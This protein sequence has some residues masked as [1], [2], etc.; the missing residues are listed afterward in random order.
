[1]LNFSQYT[2]I[3]MTLL[4]AIAIGAAG[5]SP[6]YILICL[7]FSIFPALAGIWV[8][9]NDEPPSLAQ[10]G[11]VFGWTALATLAVATTGGANSPA[12]ILFAIG[13]MT[14]FVFR[15]SQLARESTI[16]SVI[17]YLLAAALGSFGLLPDKTATHLPIGGVAAVLG[18]AQF[19]LLIWAAERDRTA[20]AATPAGATFARLPQQ[21]QRIPDNRANEALKQRNAYFASLGHD[22][23]SP[24]NAIMGYAETFKMNLKG[25][26]T[27]KQVDQASIIHESA[28]DL[29]ALVDDMM[30]L[31]KSEAGKLSI[32][33]EPLHLGDLGK[34]IMQQMQAMADRK[35]ISMTL[36][37][38]GE[39]WAMADAR[40][41]RRIW[42]NLISNAIKY[43]NEGGKVQLSASERPRH[44][45]ISVSDNGRGMT[46]EDLDRIASPFEM[47][48]NSSDKAGTGLGLANVR[49]FAEMHGGQVLIDTA[50]GEGARF[51]VILPKA[52]LSGLAPL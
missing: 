48:E 22:L 16:F 6:V 3:G 52:D 44:A 2:W 13:P 46:E 47:G 5:G 50:P 17:A 43:S 29:L 27:P 26:L 12:V 11:M 28:Q 4:A 1:M 25:N 39:P 37:T 18:I 49:R 42:Q 10:A 31:A 45:V 51:Q 14:A 40:L 30:D 7:A 20:R 15:N 34:S 36:H 24:F 9:S 32:D 8:L 23:R 33:P 41:V 21:P 19:L 38:Y 35:N